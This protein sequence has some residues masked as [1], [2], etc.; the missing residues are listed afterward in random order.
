MIACFLSVSFCV[1]IVF[2]SL[3]RSS[4]LAPSVNTVKTNDEPDLRAVG[5]RALNAYAGP[6]DGRR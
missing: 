3:F 5:L 1:F 4:I 2:L 6:S